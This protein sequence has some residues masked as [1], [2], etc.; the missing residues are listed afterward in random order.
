MHM[1]THTPEPRAAVPKQAENVRLKKRLCHG[2][3]VRFGQRQ[4]RLFMEVL[5]QALL[6]CLDPELC[7]QVNKLADSYQNQLL[8]AT[9]LT[10]CTNQGI[11]N[12]SR[13]VSKYTHQILSLSI[14]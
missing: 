6:V 10:Y 7:F 14:K 5:L 3:K 11:Q 4:K 1:Q 8:K 13:S 2:D 12:T 9:S